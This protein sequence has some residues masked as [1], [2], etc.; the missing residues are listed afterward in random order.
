[1]KKKKRLKIRAV[2]RST[3]HLGDRIVQ[4]A[5]DAQAA[6]PAP[7]YDFDKPYVGIDFAVGPDQSAIVHSRPGFTAG[8]PLTGEMVQFLPFGPSHDESL[9]YVKEALTL[10]QQH[11]VKDFIENLKRDWSVDFLDMG[12]APKGTFKPL[13]GYQYIRRHAQLERGDLLWVAREWIPTSSPGDTVLSDWV[14]IRR[15]KTQ[16]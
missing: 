7:S 6:P 15:M 14:Y 10:A 12:E 3:L 8:T 13:S 1:M 16:P 5:E 9:I 4:M 11:S 2:R